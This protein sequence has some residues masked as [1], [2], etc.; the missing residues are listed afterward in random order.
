MPRDGATRTRS[1]SSR[2]DSLATA[3]ARRRVAVKEERFCPKRKGPVR[4]SEIR[5]PRGAP[6]PRTPRFNVC[7]SD[8]PRAILGVKMACSFCRGTCSKSH[9]ILSL[10]VCGHK[11]SHL[12]HHSYFNLGARKNRQENQPSC[13][14][15][16]S[17]RP[18]SGATIWSKIRFV[19]DFRNLLFGRDFDLS[20]SKDYSL[21]KFVNL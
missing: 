5:R 13:H 14:T 12:R 20:F 11:S 6:D 18:R 2:T 4:R 19:V 3:K 16:T 8:L 10:F 9:Q 1:A 15:S 17:P 7:S 21:M